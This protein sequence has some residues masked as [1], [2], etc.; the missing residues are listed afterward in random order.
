MTPARAAVALV[1]A[2]A[3][4]ALVAGGCGSD[5]RTKVAVI[6][7]SLVNQSTTYLTDQLRDRGYEPKIASLSGAATCDLFE[8]IGRLRDDFDPDVVA[9]SF[10][11]NAIGP[12]MQHRDGSALS[13]AEYVDKYRDDT[14]RAIEMF[15]DGTSVYLV[16]APVSGTPDDRVFRIYQDLAKR[17]PNVTF[18][19]GGKYVSP[20]HTFVQ[21]LPCLRGEPQCNGPVVDGVR[22][23]VVRAPDEA[24]FCPVEPATDEPCPVYASG[25]YRFAR[26]IAEAVARGEG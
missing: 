12:C 4:A 9:F 20:N 7:D 3:A 23:N 2:A 19:D 25:G 14:E 17:Y 5:G 11:G 21:T 6:G 1:V 13:N 18:V 26:A 24:H 10:S 16:G 15:D 22:H 8:P